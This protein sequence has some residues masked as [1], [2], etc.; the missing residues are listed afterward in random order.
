M[1]NFVVYT[2]ELELDTLA[3][4]HIDGCNKEAQRLADQLR[5]PV[6]FRFNDEKIIVYPLYKDSIY[7]KE[8]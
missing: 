7:F 3:G 8:D 2:K 1:D 6:S 5:I 4:A